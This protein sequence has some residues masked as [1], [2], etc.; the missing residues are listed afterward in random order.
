L[1]EVPGSAVLPPDLAGKT[2]LGINCLKFCRL[3][4]AA[5]ASSVDCILPD[6]DITGV[7][8][9]DAGINILPLSDG[10]PANRKWDHVVSDAMLSQS[11]HPFGDIAALA[12]ATTSTLT[13]GVS[14]IRFLGMKAGALGVIAGVLRALPVVIAGNNGSTGKS[15]APKFFFSRRS[16]REVLLRHRSDFASLEF[17]KENRK[18]FAR[19]EKRRIG[20]L[21]MVSGPV[22]AGKSTFMEKLLSGKLPVV[23]GQLG[24]KPDERPPVLGTSSKAPRTKAEL[25]VAISH[26]GFLRPYMRPAAVCARDEALDVIDVAERVTVVTLQVDSDA[27]VE[28]ITR[29]EIDATPGGKASQ[30]H[31]QLREEYRNPRRLAEHYER[32]IKYVEGRGLRHFLA[33]EEAGQ[34]KLVEA[35]SLSLADQESG[36]SLEWPSRETDQRHEFALRALPRDMT[37]LTLLDVDCGTGEVCRIAMERG[38]A[39]VVG[40]DL[41]AEMLAEARRRCPGVEFRQATLWEMPFGE[42]F[43]VVT[44]RSRLSYERDVTGFMDALI[45]RA[46][47]H[48]AFGFSSMDE[49]SRKRTGLPWIAA[50]ALAKLP[51]IIALKNGT[52]SNREQPRFAICKPAIS[53]M[54]TRHRKVF[55][56]MSFRTYGSGTILSAEKFRIPHLIVVAGPVSAGKSTLCNML[57]QG[58]ADFIYERLGVEK[59]RRPK[60]VYLPRAR[61]S[62]PPTGECVL[63]HYNMLNAYVSTAAIHEND[64]NLDIMRLADRLSVLTIWARPEQLVQQ[65]T[66]SEIDKGPFHRPTRRHLQLREEYRDPARVRFHYESWNRFVSGLTTENWMV[67]RDGTGAPQ[68]QSVPDWRRE[69]QSGEA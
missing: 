13:I 43:D 40:I 30:R 58:K 44:C 57:V 6:G 35:S 29:G 65:I 8:L 10:I 60:F 52:A 50:T 27:L 37:G 63:F 9:A 4:K 26:Y 48:V 1:I 23:A 21:I 11:R 55:S 3:A 54:L 64:E 14:P 51:T 19:A 59:E 32:W 46:V 15:Q 16:L 67:S 7:S 20:H 25:P 24:L 69:T 39:K 45:A 66:K 2:F 28:R 68:M 31:V 56:E 41:S 38:A 18:L 22:A 53:R 12:K 49:G 61:S 42:K 33:V 34:V 36:G 5:G 47:R 62:G 17:I